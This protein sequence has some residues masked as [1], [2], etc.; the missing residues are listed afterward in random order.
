MSHL[1][2]Y[3]FWH[4]FNQWIKGQF[5]FDGI[6][7][8]F[9]WHYDYKN[10]YFKYKKDYWGITTFW[11]TIKW[12]QKMYVPFCAHKNFRGF[13]VVCTVEKSYVLWWIHQS[14]CKWFLM[15][16]LNNKACRLQICNRHAFIKAFLLKNYQTK[17][18]MFWCF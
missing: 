3:I 5:H 16:F 10:V 6:V 17:D 8:D 2:T 11:Y 13:E 4:Y 14:F 1:G 18:L 7:P 12:Y 9:I 15:V